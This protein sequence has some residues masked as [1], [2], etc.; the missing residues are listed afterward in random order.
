MEFEPA[1]IPDTL[2]RRRAL[3]GAAAA[4]G[5]GAV[6]LANPPAALA[7]G[8]EYFLNALDFNAKGDGKADDTEALQDVI[9]A[10]QETG[11][12]IYLPPGN[13]KTTAGLATT[14]S[15]FAMFGAGA[16]L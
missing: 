4:G 16:R 8:S 7:A 5:L 9:D 11:L 3:V 2:T 6:A 10:A 14:A 13:Y 1:Q 12:P 15:D